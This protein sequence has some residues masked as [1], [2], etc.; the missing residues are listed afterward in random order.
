[1][2]LNS[3]GAVAEEAINNAFEVEITNKMIPVL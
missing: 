2:I 1:M 3:D